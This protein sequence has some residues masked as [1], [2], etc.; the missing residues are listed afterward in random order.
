MDSHHNNLHLNGESIYPTPTGSHQDAP[1]IPQRPQLDLE[2]DKSLYVDTDSS[3]NSTSSSYSTSSSTPYTLDNDSAINNVESM[4]ITDCNNVDHQKSGLSFCS[5][6]KSHFSS[7]F[8]SKHTSTSSLVSLMS[9]SPTPHNQNNGN[10]TSVASFVSTNNNASRSTLRTALASSSSIATSTN[11]SL[12]THIPDFELDLD[13]DVSSAYSTNQNIGKDSTSPSRNEVSS[14]QKISKLQQLFDKIIKSSYFLSPIDELKESTRLFE[15]PVDLVARIIGHLTPKEVGSLSHTCKWVFV[16]IELI[17]EQ[18][19]HNMIQARTSRA[20]RKAFLADFPDSTPFSKED[21]DIELKCRTKGTTTRNLDTGPRAVYNYLAKDQLILNKFS[22]LR[23]RWYETPKLWYHLLIADR[24][25]LN[26]LHDWVISVIKLCSIPYNGK[27]NIPHHSSSIEEAILTSCSN[28]FPSN[29]W[30]ML[31]P[32]RVTRSRVAATTKINISQ[33]ERNK[34]NK[35]KLPSIYSTGKKNHIDVDPI[36]KSQRVGKSVDI[37]KGIGSKKHKRAS[38]LRKFNDMDYDDDDIYEDES[39]NK[40]VD[41]MAAMLEGININSDSNGSFLN[42]N[43]YNDVRY[44]PDSELRI[45]TSRFVSSEEGFQEFINILTSGVLIDSHKLIKLSY[46]IQEHGLNCKSVW[47]SAELFE[48]VY[49]SPLKFFKV[50]RDDIN[51]RNNLVDFVIANSDG[52]DTGTESDSSVD[53]NLILNKKKGL[54][55]ESFNQQN[56]NSLNRNL[57]SNIREST[58][59]SIDSLASYASSNSD[60]G[61][62][63]SAGTKSKQ[64]QSIANSVIYNLLLWPNIKQQLHARVTSTLLLLN[65]LVET[66]RLYGCS[67]VRLSKSSPM[68]RTTGAKFVRY[69]L[70]KV[71]ND[72]RKLLLLHCISLLKDGETFWV[73]KS[74]WR[75]DAIGFEVYDFERLFIRPFLRRDLKIGYIISPLGRAQSNSGNVSSPLINGWS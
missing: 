59:S 67:C 71:G 8:P 33:Q 49:G 62:A 38:R 27:N 35:S 29:I 2:M 50:K 65:W 4:D 16:Y 22:S 25:D 32:S 46:H 15:L 54:N 17:K 43:Y 57:S 31:E 40:D 19:Y 48:T 7:A 75:N 63:V 30:F 5:N 26:V 34:L 28:Y 6:Q 24:A 10:I 52:Y 53:S 55:Y 21:I 61:S 70:P 23:L 68:H 45:L 73:D 56:F 44:I 72:R 3:S 18:I 9:S 13:P 39:S 64:L 74:E 20:L 41:D 60:T 11:T 37:N 36:T 58:F 47:N 51:L 12:A 69:V 14:K 42:N 66:L 1:N